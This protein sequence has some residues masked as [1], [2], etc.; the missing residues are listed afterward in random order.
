MRCRAELFLW[1]DFIEG[2]LPTAQLKLQASTS[3]KLSGARKINHDHDHDIMTDNSV[4]IYHKT[5]N[6]V[7]RCHLS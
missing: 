4:D 2:K 3:L 6:S 5:N 7:Q 1:G